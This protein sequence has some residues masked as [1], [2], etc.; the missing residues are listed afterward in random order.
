MNEL[1]VD[2]AGWAAWLDRSEQFH[3]LAVKSV[4]EA[5]DL[6]RILVTT[7]WIFA[8]L[9]GL[10]TRFRMP[11]SQQIQT[12]RRLRSDPSILVV[13]VVSSVETS[14]WQLW[15]TRP[16]K[17]WSLV[18]CA[19]FVVMEARKITNAMTSDHHFEQ[20]GFIRLLT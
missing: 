7:N 9:T 2:T 11:K 4:N 18:D 17:E 20:D 6:G 13:P 8:E 16:D 14:A 10:L 1:F 3:M 19:S 15:E 12:L 5:W